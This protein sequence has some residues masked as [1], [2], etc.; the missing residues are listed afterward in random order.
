M[1]T[2]ES[3][4]LFSL[5]ALT[6]SVF[7]VAMCLLQKRDQWLFRTFALVLLCSGLT[8]LTSFPWP[9]E[10][11]IR[12]ANVD[13]ISEL[14]WLIALLCLPPLFWHYICVLTSIV[15]K[16]PERLWLHCTLP[17]IGVFVACLVLAMPQDARFGL[18][19]DGYDLPSGYFLAVGIAGEFLSLLALL[20]WG[21]YFIAIF[22]RLLR[23]RERVKDYFATTEKR[24]LTW[25]WVLILFLAAYWVTNAF[26]A[27]WEIGT[28]DGIFPQ[29][30]EDIT[31]FSLLF[32][33]LLWGLRQRPAFA[34]DEPPEDTA[35][36]YENSALSKD[37]AAR[38]V[39]KLRNAMEQDKLHHDP[40]LSLWKHRNCYR[41]A[42]ILFWMSH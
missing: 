30:I 38:L 23:H 2:L 32:L 15:P 34:P 8:D 40:N 18:F 9:I 19:V 22:R 4:D 17:F 31:A 16:L 10:D 39:R 3:T 14:I 5:S 42:K 12:H 24:E 11:S 41:V 1:L 36:K 37:M 20:Q 13:V 29:W 33:V 27:I 6:L 28:E 7:G 21:A 26:D 35:T 25:I